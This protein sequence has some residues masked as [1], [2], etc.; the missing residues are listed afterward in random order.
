MFQLALV[1]IAPFLTSYLLKMKNQ[2]LSVSNNDEWDD[3]EIDD[4]DDYNEWLRQKNE[5]GF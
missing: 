1:F 3:D 5:T 2:M 4:L